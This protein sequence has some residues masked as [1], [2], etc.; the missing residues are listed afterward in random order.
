M[1]LCNKIPKMIDSKLLI[2]GILR[3]LQINFLKIKDIV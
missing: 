3:I 2:L 1:N